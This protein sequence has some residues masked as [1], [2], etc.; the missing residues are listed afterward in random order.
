MSSTIAAPQTHPRDEAVR[1]GATVRKPQI[2]ITNAT[3]DLVLEARRVVLSYRNPQGHQACT[4]AAIEKVR[5]LAKELFSRDFRSDRDHGM[6]PVFYHNAPNFVLLHGSARATRNKSPEK[7]EAIY[8]II[9]DKRN[10]S[11]YDALKT[12]G[13]LLSAASHDGRLPRSPESDMLIS[14]LDAAA[15]D[16]AETVMKAQEAMKQRYVIPPRM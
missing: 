5:G 14:A 8:N 13:L 3:Q 4:Y 9:L 10:T 11:I 6:L 2:E 16:L 12:A 7:I 15:K 1:R